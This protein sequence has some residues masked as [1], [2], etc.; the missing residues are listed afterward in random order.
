M[1]SH[2][3]IGSRRALVGHSGFVGTTLL[4]Q[5]TFS[6]IYR[7]TDI[8]D[9]AGH[10][11]DLLVC[12]GAPAQKWLANKKP[13]DDRHN[14][15]RLISALHAVE[16]EF[17]VLISTVD[18]FRDPRGVDEDSEVDLDGLHAYGANRY[19]LEKFIQDHFPKYLILRLPGLVGPGLRK[20]IIFD[21]LNNNNIEKID[22]RGVFQFYPMVNLWA[23]INKAYESR[24]EIA[25]LTS[26]PLSVE[27]ISVLGFAQP[28]Q[29]QIGGVPAEYDLQSQYAKLFG[30]SGRYQYC[31]R[32]V[33]QAVRWYAQ[34]EPLLKQ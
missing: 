17:C 9:I 4:K 1:N 8:E 10:K 11:F 3:N 2:L 23:D 12:A 22:S 34:S 24:L 33:I 29:N 7:S 32:D 28:F 27:E 13:E 25:H 5:T 15:S 26:E 6:N 20:N 30:G 21:F 18:V 16:A 31:K 14:I 19:V